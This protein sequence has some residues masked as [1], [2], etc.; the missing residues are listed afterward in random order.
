MMMLLR[1]LKTSKLNS[2]EVKADDRFGKRQFDAQ[3]TVL[4]VKN[5]M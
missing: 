3:Y 4:M 2:I 5:R 1:N